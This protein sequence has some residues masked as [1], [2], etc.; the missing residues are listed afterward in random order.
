MVLLDSQAV[1]R[2]IRLAGVLLTG[3]TMSQ[4][5]SAF[6]HVVQK[7]ESVA[8]I[9][10]AMYGRVQLERVIVAVNVLDA[11]GGTVLVSG[12]RLEIPAVGY[13][14][15]SPGETWHSIAAELLGASKRGDVLATLN[16]AQPWLRPAPGREI[17]IPYN[18]RYVASRGDTSQALAYRFLGR[19]DKAWVV[20]A[21][22]GLKRA[23]LRHGEV[24]LV[25]LTDL[26]LTETGKRAALRAGALVR[27]Q[28]GGQARD[29]QRF[30]EREIPQLVGDVRGGRYVEAVRKGASLLARAGLSQPQ[31]AVVYRQLTEA[32]VALDAVGL[33]AT[34]CAE[35]RRADPRA[36]LDPIEL[37]PKILG[38]CT[39]ERRPTDG[40]AAARPDAG[41]I[42][43]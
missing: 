34:S 6:P 14:Q 42:G 3:L 16:G 15:V 4:V 29:A 40:A 25:P 26:A 32:Y 37:S 11:R 12:M 41:G 1:R 27:T 38:A 17:V 33:A 10:E 36:A 18:L 2:W 31:R 8:Q 23:Q 30:A 5:S 20:A 19:R 43:R 9:A 35:W 24:V 39:G 21:Y 22:N 7:G 13:H 28:A